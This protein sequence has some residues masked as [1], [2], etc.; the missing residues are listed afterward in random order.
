[1]CFDLEIVQGCLVP[2]RID[3]LINAQYGA[4]GGLNRT[5]D[6]RAFQDRNAFTVDLLL[7]QGRLE[8]FLI[9]ANLLQLR[10]SFYRSA[11]KAWDFGLIISR[12]RCEQSHSNNGTHEFLHLRHCRGSLPT[13]LAV[14][15]PTMK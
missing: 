2:G 15:A 10:D 9:V 13:N 8:C 5:F 14:L 3:L 12:L 4:I 11:A 1:L 7:K 6:Y